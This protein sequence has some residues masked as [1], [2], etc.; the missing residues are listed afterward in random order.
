MAPG[1]RSAG[2]KERSLGTAGGVPTC[3]SALGLPENMCENPVGA[4]GL[5]PTVVNGMRAPAS[6]ISALR[7]RACPLA[8]E[9]GVWSAA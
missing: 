7:K 4:L 2:N 3:M 8:W 6:P 1:H 5:V 9:V